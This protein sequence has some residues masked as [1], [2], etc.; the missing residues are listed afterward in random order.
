MV[1]HSIIETGGLPKNML[2]K[3]RFFEKNGYMIG[4]YFYSLND[5]ENGILRGNK[6]AP[7]AFFPPFKQNDPR[8]KYIVRP[9]DPRIHFALNCGALSCPSIKVYSP[10]KIDSQLKLATKSFLSQTLTVKQNSLELSKI[11]SWYRCDFGTDEELLT[12][13]KENV[14]EEVQNQI[15]KLTRPLKLTFAPYDWSSN[16]K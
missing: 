4:G 8:L 7:S 5:I 16:A 14:S 10:E 1:V 2:S 6:T 12:L 15:D 9:M 3:I 11:F 13:I